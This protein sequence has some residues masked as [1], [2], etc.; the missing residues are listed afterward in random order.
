MLNTLA[1]H[2]YLPHSGKDI[3]VNKTIDALG[4]ALNIDAE[5]ATFLHSFAV[6]TNPTPNATIF[7]LDNLSRHNILE[8]DGSLRYVQGE[9]F[10]IHVQKWDK[11]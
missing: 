3:N 9:I 2:G 7:S 4:Q 8:H 6:T 11:I 10:A 1:N 5:L